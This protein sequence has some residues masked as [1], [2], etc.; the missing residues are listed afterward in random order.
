MKTLLSLI[1]TFVTQLIQK[2]VKNL[3]VIISSLDLSSHGSP[4][5]YLIKLECQRYQKS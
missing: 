4:L 5:Y 2:I 1:N 3:P